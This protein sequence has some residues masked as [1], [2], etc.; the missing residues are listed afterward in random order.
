MLYI[1]WF[2]FFFFFIVFLLFNQACVFEDIHW[3]QGKYFSG[4]LWKETM[5]IL[6]LNLGY[7]FNGLRLQFL[8]CQLEAPC[9]RAWIPLP[10]NFLDGSSSVAYCNVI[11]SPFFYLLFQKKLL[12][13]IYKGEPVNLII[14]SVI[15]T[16]ILFFKEA[17]Q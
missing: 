7:V 8:W 11:F 17:A 12:I 15:S 13:W 14:M 2:K 6:E 9:K 10:L 5:E 1:I 3:I 16:G 4:Q